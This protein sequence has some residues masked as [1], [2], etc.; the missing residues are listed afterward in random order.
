MDLWGTRHAD[1]HESFYAPPLDPA[2]PDFN[3]PQQNQSPFYAAPLDAAAPDFNPPQ[4]GQSH[5]YAAPLNRAPPNF[6]PP[7]RNRSLYNDV[8]SS[9]KPPTFYDPSLFRRGQAKPVNRPRHKRQTKGSTMGTW[10]RD[11]I[12]QPSLES[13]GIPDPTPLYLQLASHPPYV[14][15]RR[16]DLLVVVD[17]NGTLLYRPSHRNPTRFIQRPHARQFLSYCVNTFTVVIWSSARPRSVES[18]CRQLLEPKDRTKVVATMAR[19]RFGLS[20][21][22]YNQRVLCYKRLTTVWNDPT[23]ARSHPEAAYGKKWNQLNTVLV[24]D[25]LDKARSEP[26]NL[27]QIPEFKGD[28]REPGSILLQVQDY[29]NECNRRMNVSAYIR[30]QPFAFNPQFT[31]GSRR[32]IKVGASQVN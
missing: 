30:T 16:Q 13:G 8:P 6:N 32:S 1:E 7:Q 26:Y 20:E 28:P 29:F 9:R 5:F 4:Q 12:L 21:T 25:S 23:I 2:A 14:L 27:I 22:D 24:D 11:K 19:D 31:P 17:L 3:P 10:P 15:P 18:M